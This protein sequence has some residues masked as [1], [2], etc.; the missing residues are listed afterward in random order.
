MPLYAIHCLDKPNSLELRLT[1][2]ER[3]LAYVTTHP[4]FRMG[5]PYLNAEGQPV[6]S[7]IFIEAEDEAAAKAFCAGDPY[8]Q[9]GLFEVVE[10][11]PWAYAGGKLP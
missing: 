2:R 3:H 5:G 6:G 1:T 4:T 10:I 11:R 8:G 7:L 9:A